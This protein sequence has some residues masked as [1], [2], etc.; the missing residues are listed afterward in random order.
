MSRIMSFLG[1]LINIYMMIIFIRIILT[2]FSWM[3]NSKFQEILTKITDPY[4]NWF[5]RFE[6]LRIGFL[7]LSPIAA[8]GVL[9][10]VSRIVTTLARYGTITVGIILAMIL[11][12][13]WGAVS[14]FLGFLIIIL[15]LYLIAGLTSQD[16]SNPFWRIIDTISRPVLL[17][18]NSIFFKDRIVK[19]QTRIIIS[20]AALG[21]LYVILSILVSMVSAI[22]ARLPF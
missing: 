3:G 22:L 16:I 6:F 14:F 11:Q 7:D 8:L 15:L 1:F 2:W 12:A 9:S 21:I 4:L 10:L 17:K 19:F 18:I 5:R 20:V 13:V